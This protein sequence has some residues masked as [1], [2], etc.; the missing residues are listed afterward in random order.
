MITAEEILKPVTPM[1][2]WEVNHQ[3]TPQYRGM[4]V[5]FQGQVIAALTD[6][7]QTG[8]QIAE[9]IGATRYRVSSVLCKLYLDGVA[10]KLAPGV[11]RKAKS[12]MR[13]VRNMAVH[14]MEEV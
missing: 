9:K 5:G 7:G 14:D 12:T 1:R 6:E 4:P 10:E 11:Y 3:I 2:E 8:A 13:T